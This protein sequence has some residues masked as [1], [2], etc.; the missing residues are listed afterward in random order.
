VHWRPQSTWQQEDQFSDGTLRLMGLLWAA[1]DGTGPL[2]LEEPELSLHPEF[3]R[4]IPQVFARLQRRS[5]RQVLVS[6]H[7]PDLLQDDGIGLDEVLL[8]LPS[9]EGTQVQPAGSFR[10]IRALLERG[11]SMAEAVLPKTAPQKMEQLLF[12]FGDDH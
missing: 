2:L 1:L 12:A 8:L 4:F 11:L 3:V 5:G 10:D 6:T 7:S 9:E